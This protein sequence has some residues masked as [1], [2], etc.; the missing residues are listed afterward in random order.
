MQKLQGFAVSPGVAIGEALVLDHEGFRIPRRFV[1]RDVVASEI[2]RLERAIEAAGQEIVRH[3]DT[4]ARELGPQCAAIFEAHLQM[5]HDRPLRN[6]LEEMIRERHYTPEYAVSRTLRRYA[7]VFQSL[8]NTYLAQRASDVFDIERRLLRY[9]LGE[10]REEVAYL[11]SPVLV[12]AHNLTPS[13]TANL[14]REFVRGLVTE[15][16]G[17][18]SH[19]AILAGALEIP[20]IV[21]TGPFLTDVSGGDL[22]IIDGDRGQVILHPDEETI[23]R[24]THEQ[25]QQRS[26]AVRLESLRD[27]PAQTAD[28]VRIQLMG[29]IEFPHEVQHCLDRGSDGIGLYR[30]EFLY[31][32]SSTEP[33]EETHYAAYSQ[34]VQAI[35]NRPV[36]IRTLDLGADKVPSMPH[37]A[38]ERNPFLG[39]RSI[40]LSLRNLPLFRTQL[41]AVLRASALGDV[42][43]MFPLISTLLELRQA[44]MLL[45]D[46]MEDLDENGIPFNRNLDVGMMVEV[47]AAVMM[48]DQFAAEVDFVS[49]GTNDLIQYTL[50]VDR[51]NK[52]VAAL[53]NASDPAVLKLIQRAVEASVRAGIPVNVCG[54]MS[55]ST[56][57]TM[58]L[59]GLGLRQLS[60]TPSSIPEVKKVIRSVNI[61]H[62]EA[63]ARHALTL[64]HARD[65]KNYLKGELKRLFP[66]LAE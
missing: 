51:G 38:D 12:L 57:Y 49:I 43:V 55:G 19:T 3:R 28:G 8:D 66:E 11:T 24:Y 30:T 13:E 47:P 45:A 31:L 18:G 5:L 60:V 16:G 21:G 29:N 53:Y 27:L 20:A 46:V 6:E 14:N 54:Q 17:P 22:V 40:R 50:A 42:R 61:P 36:V 32:G 37:P 33:D 58:L 64:E 39:L 63:V 4:V 59:L 23:A 25:Q 56:T 15:E 41:R 34:V 65:V 62:C 52:D 48:M 7:K 1:D 9:L 44:K 35:G 2:A 10:R 26:H